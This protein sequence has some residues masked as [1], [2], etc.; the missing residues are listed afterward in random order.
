MGG[1]DS[2]LES[3]Y[4]D[5]GT[6]NTPEEKSKLKQDGKKTLVGGEFCTHVVNNKAKDGEALA[7]YPKT[8][9]YDDIEK[10]IRAQ[11]FSFLNNG[12]VSN[13]KLQKKTSNFFRNSELINNTNRHRK[14]CFQNKV[15][16]QI[17]SFLITEVK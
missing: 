1:K 13:F 9:T 7:D 6:F 11:S 5:S 2:G 12:V 3:K 4:G 14:Y 8:Q 17:N 10:E 15:Q 16:N